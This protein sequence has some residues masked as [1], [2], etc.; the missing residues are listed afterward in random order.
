MEGSVLSKTG[1]ID[2]IKGAFP[3]MPA[4][5]GP[6]TDPALIRAQLKRLLAGPEF[7]R[8]ERMASFLTE[9][10]NATLSQ[11][12]AR[13]TER[14][15]GK[16]VFGKE[17]DWDPRGDTIVRSEARR[18]RRKLREFYQGHAQDCQVFIELP[19]GSYVAKFSRIASI[20]PEVQSPAPNIL[21]SAADIR[22]LLPAV[23]SLRQKPV[24][25]LWILVAALLIAAFGL[26]SQ[27]VSSPA[28]S[29]AFTIVPFADQIG[30]EYS[31]AV[32]PD[33]RT[34]AYTWDGNVG[35]PNIYLKN[36]DGTQLRQLT[37]GEGDFYSPAWSPDGKRISYLRVREQKVD[38]IVHD[39]A[40]GSEQVVIGVRK[41]TGRWSSN[42]GILLGDIGPEWSNGGKSL[43]IEDRLF[44]DAGVGG[45]YR[46]DIATG[47]R[48]QVTFA[49]GE[50]R[51]FTPRISHDGRTLAFVRYFSH[52]HGELFTVPVHGGP[53]RQLT[54]DLRDI[55]GIT[56][57]QDGNSLIFCS[58]RS[59]YFQL[60]S[61]S[62][63]GG[64]PVLLDTSTTSATS[65]TAFHHSIRLAFVD[66]GENWNIWRYPV[67]RGHL[68]PAKLIL[69]SSGRNHDPRYS[70]DGK[71][72]AFIS[73]RSGTLEVWTASADGSAATQVTD[74]GG[75]WVNSLTWS[76][77]ASRIAFDARLSGNAAIYDIPAKGGKL[78]LIDAQKGVEERMPSWTMRS[79]LIY[80]NSVRDGSVA[81]YLKSLS[82]QS[83]V[84]VS[85]HEMYTVAL[86]PDGKRLYFSDRSGNLWQAKP[87]GSD[88]A[89]LNIQAFPVK[90]WAPTAHGIVFS[91]GDEDKTRSEICLYEGGVVKVLG[92]T[93]GALVSHDPDV[94]LSPDGKWLLVAQQDLMHSDIKL[95]VSQ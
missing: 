47:T 89:A 61:L 86:S 40:T 69:S 90:S 11:E 63:S 91:S 2:E 36:T 93:E 7:F 64:K 42:H 23:L 57:S 45:I 72:I 5:V 73:D 83:V 44:S 60:W 87:D 46:I 32:S 26:R 82:D 88:A 62:L 24:I 70:P 34:I 12:P 15:I 95:R 28:E 52:G 71:Q 4:T 3:E 54:N 67:E 37:S 38:L 35:R 10:V 80:F 49:P 1:Q 51:D 17:R 20:T 94:S 79:N 18:L 27:R 85:E 59:S 65:P 75:T 29:N 81:I 9:V 55:Q 77:D 84:R 56:W 31:P 33:D 74:L 53:A 41:E 48:E 43:F 58:N 22:P 14:Q 30:Q 50:E 92:L 76:P 21:P 6:E 19:V 16:T 68:G 25:S 66:A 39:I 13:L 8:S 78:Q